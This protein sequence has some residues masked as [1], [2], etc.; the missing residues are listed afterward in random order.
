MISDYSIIHGSRLY[1]SGRR[2]GGATMSHEE[3]A[4]AFVT[5]SAQLQ[6]VQR[7][8]AA[9]Q[10]TTADLRQNMNRGGKSRE[11]IEAISQKKYTTNMQVSGNFKSWAENMNVH[12]F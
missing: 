9:E 5:M 3:I 7:S 1:T 2:K 11:I 6:Q 12:L 10:A 8:L 4:N